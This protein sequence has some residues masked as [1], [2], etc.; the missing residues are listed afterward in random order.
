MNSF[1]IRLYAVAA[2]IVGTT[3]IGWLVKLETEPPPVEVPDWSL[4]ALPIQLGEWHGKEE[5][6]DP[7]VFAATNA[8][9]V[10]N[11]KYQDGGGHEVSLHTAMFQDHNAGVYHSP[12]NC[13]RSAGWKLVSET[14]ET[15]EVAEDLTIKVNMASWEREQDKVLVVYWYELGGHVLYSRRDLGILR[16]TAMRGQPKWPVLFKMMV[17][18][19]VTDLETS[20]TLVLDFVS[21]LAKWMHQPA[22][23]K[24]LDQWRGV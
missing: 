16:L 24:Y 18:G 11:R 23:R 2:I 19:P 3:G 17:Q 22:H 20:K 9:V 4:R 14:S 15:V 8:D 5:A 1:A 13:Y 7:K 6:L 10:V 12:L 21:Q